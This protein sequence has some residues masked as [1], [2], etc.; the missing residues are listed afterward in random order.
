M[1]I[2]AT[3]PLIDKSKI[4]IFRYISLIK[5]TNKKFCTSQYV[6]YKQTHNVATFRYRQ[7]KAHFFPECDVLKK[8]VIDILYL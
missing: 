8:V 2:L 4:Y 6:F 3:E 7:I 5:N 1:E